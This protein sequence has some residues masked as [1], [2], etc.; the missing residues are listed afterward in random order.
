MEK[1]T[2][3]SSGAKGKSGAPKRSDIDRWTSDGYGIVVT[4]TAKQ[5]QKGKK[6]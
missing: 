4:K 3:K 2:K 1:N 5:S 6:K